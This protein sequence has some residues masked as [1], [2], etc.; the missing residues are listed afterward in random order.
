MSQSCLRGVRRLWGLLVPRKHIEMII[1]GGDGG[2][3]KVVKLGAWVDNTRRRASQ[4]G[5]QRRADLDALGMRW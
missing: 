2:R 3:E 5:D 1:V 4:L